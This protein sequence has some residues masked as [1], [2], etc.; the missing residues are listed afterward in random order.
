MSQGDGCAERGIGRLAGQPSVE[1]GG[2]T[3][4]QRQGFSAVTLGERWPVFL[5]NILDALAGVQGMAAQ[6]MHGGV[7]P[8]PHAHCS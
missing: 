4:E 1:V 7:I 8:Y 2:G 5:A 3:F 6:F